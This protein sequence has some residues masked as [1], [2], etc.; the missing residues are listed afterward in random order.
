[1]QIGL[2][3]FTG[4]GFLSLCRD[5]A[6]EPRDADVWNDSARQSGSQRTGVLQSLPL[7]KGELYR[8][9]KFMIVVTRVFFDGGMGSRK[10]PAAHR[11]DSG[12]LGENFGQGVRELA[13]H[14]GNIVF[15]AVVFGAHGPPPTLTG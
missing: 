3:A 4:L 15:G 2:V 11:A 8:S 7:R 9:T 1:M 6:A 13:A 12:I 10:P 5:T 14:C